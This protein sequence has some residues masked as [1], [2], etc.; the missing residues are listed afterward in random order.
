MNTPTARRTASVHEISL[1]DALDLLPGGDWIH[2]FIG[3]AQP[4]GREAPRA[5]VI[6]AIHAA[7]G[8]WLCHVPDFGHQ[9]RLGRSGYWLTVQVD[10]GRAGA[11][12]S[13]LEAT[14]SD[15]GVPLAT[16]PLERK[17]TAHV[18]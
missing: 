17:A 18:R 5:E 6:D 15:A 4:Q 3:S 11:L 2:T 10:A 12:R 9:L 7:D 1:T 16:L 14:R 13:R 8:C